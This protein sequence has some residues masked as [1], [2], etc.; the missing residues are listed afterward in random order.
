MASR[1]GLEASNR[2][3]SSMLRGMGPDPTHA[4]P[5]GGGTGRPPPRGGRPTRKSSS[6]SR[7]SAPVPDRP[8]VTRLPSPGEAAP[9][10]HEV[11]QLVELPLEVL[12]VGRPRDR[13]VGD[14]EIAAL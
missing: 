14:G 6:P 10:V 13:R 11:L 5:A 9:V 3:T 2:S 8:S 7:R 12:H 1:R 4:P